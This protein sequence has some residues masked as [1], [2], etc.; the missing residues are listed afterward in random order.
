MWRRELLPGSETFVRSQ[1]DGLKNWQGIALGATKIPSPIAEPSDQILFARRR[2]DRLRNRLF[3]WTRYSLALHR[4]L[5]QLKPDIVHAHFAMDGILIAPVCQLLRIPFVVS[6]YGIDVTAMAARSG[7]RGAIYRSRLESMFR[8]S[9]KILAVSDHL[10]DAARLLGAPSDKVI[11]HRLGIELPEPHQHR[12]DGKWDVLVVGRLVEKKGI[13]DLIHAASLI[14]KLDDKPIQVA[15]IGDGP[16]RQSLEDTALRLGLSVDFL[17][18]QSPSEV[19]HAMRRS[20]ILAVPSKTASNGDREG[21]PMILLEG[22]ALG[23]PIVAT[24]HSGIPEFVTHDVTGLLSDERDTESLASNICRLLE[25]EQY[26][27]ELAQKALD[28]VTNDY[29]IRTQAELLEKIY[30]AAIRS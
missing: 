26:G 20:R 16:L 8:R 27:K 5:R 18:A 25:D 13:D 22:A 24:R 30:D 12:V 10:A 2:F 28:R 3:T 19:K 7:I 15:V 17:G 6:V 11:V 21:L 4:R 29:N 1:L 14:K 23:L 9:A